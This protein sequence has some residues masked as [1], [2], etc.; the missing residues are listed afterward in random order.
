[1]ATTITTGMKETPRERGQKSLP[2]T[3]N[4]SIGRNQ[5]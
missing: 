2:A 1:M 4:V 3:V 5:P